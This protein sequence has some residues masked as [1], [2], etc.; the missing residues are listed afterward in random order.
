MAEFGPILSRAITRVRN[1]WCPQ[2]PYIN[3]NCPL[4]TNTGCWGNCV[5]SIRDFVLM[6]G[7][8][9]MA[10]AK[11]NHYCSEE[12]SGRP[13]DFANYLSR[14]CINRSTL[15]WTVDH[16]QMPGGWKVPPSAWETRVLAVLYSWVAPSRKRSSR[17]G[18]SAYVGFDAITSPRIDHSMDI[19]AP[20][21]AITTVRYWPAVLRKATSSCVA[22]DP[23]CSGPRF[24]PEGLA[25][26]VCI[27]GLCML[28][29]HAFQSNRSTINDYIY[30]SV[31]SYGHS[32]GA[33]A[34]NE[35]ICESDLFSH[36]ILATLRGEIVVWSEAISRNGMHTLRSGP[37][38][39][40]IDAGICQKK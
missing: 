19:V 11:T 40:A 8:E 20:E 3:D 25:D 6:I 2:A 31:D 23:L 12:L 38:H 29:K 21:M 34:P 17:K 39:I 26:L 37:C 35:P 24:T 32:I 18:K 4:T 10:R 1:L 27:P 36:R 30:K 13:D 16:I 33:S 9:Y 5:D 28:S 7:F 15:K 14:I 22:C